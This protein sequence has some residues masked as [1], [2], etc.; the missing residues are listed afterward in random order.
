MHQCSIGY[1]SSLPL[2]NVIGE[3][4]LGTHNV[5]VTHNINFVVTHH[6][7]ATFLP[8]TTINTNVATTTNIMEDTNTATPTTPPYRGVFLPLPSS[9]SGNTASGFAYTLTKGCDI[10][11]DLLKSCADLFSAN[12]GVWGAHAGVVSQY[13]KPGQ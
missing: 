3:Q 13:T 11:D 12:Y 2:Q 10:T 7:N 9:P 5:T 4:E 1:F 6:T 8:S